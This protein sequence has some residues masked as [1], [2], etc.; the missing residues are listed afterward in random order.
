MIKNILNILH[1]YCYVHCSIYSNTSIYR[2]K[3][4][5]KEMVAAVSCH[6]CQT[7]HPLQALLHWCS[8]SVPSTTD[9]RYQLN[10]M[11]DICGSICL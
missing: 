8:L 10:Y 2:S 9:H 1:F 11:R 7:V 5:Y 3:V 6:H 4:F